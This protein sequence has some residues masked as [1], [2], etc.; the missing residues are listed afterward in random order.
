MKKIYFLLFISS[1]FPTFSIVAVDTNTNEVGSAGGSCIGNSIIISDMH[2]GI[3]VIH[4]QSYWLP[5]NQNYASTLM[6]EGYSPQEII[7]LL[8]ENDIQ[9]NPTLRQYGV[10]DLYQENDYGIMYEYECDE[11]DGAIWYGLSEN[12]QL[13]QCADPIIARSA[14][15]TGSNCLNWKGHINGINYA[16]QGNI[17]ID[18]N[19]LN[20]AR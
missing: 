10:V 16:I 2:P 7:E 1:L 12:N 5:A 14:S 15:F 3:G 4:T 20:A 13:G 19:V 9:N 18:E 6:I 17:L 11:I 8:E